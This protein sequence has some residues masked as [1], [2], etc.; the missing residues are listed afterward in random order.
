[1]RVRKRQHDFTSDVNIVTFNLA[2]HLST[3]VCLPRFRDAKFA[4]KHV[5]HVD[6]NEKKDDCMNNEENKQHGNG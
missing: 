6:G 1:M 4:R 3:E 2:K 5:F